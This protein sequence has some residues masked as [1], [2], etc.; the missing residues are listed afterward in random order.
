MG[1]GGCR[2]GI[3]SITNLC[4]AVREARYPYD[5]R[6]MEDAN[7]V[8]VHPWTKLRLWRTS[9]PPIAGFSKGY[10]VSLTAS[11]KVRD[12]Y[13]AVPATASPHPRSTHT[14]LRRKAMPNLNFFLSVLTRRHPRAITLFIK[15]YHKI[16]AFLT[17]FLYYLKQKN[18]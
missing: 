11:H 1:G 2:N 13:N 12:R 6:I 4:T 10:Q 16:L 18:E 7:G 15:E 5:R 9:C 8:L 14:L 3:V 17:R